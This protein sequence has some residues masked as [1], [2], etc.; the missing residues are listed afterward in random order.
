MISLIAALDRRHAIGRPDLT[1]AGNGLPWHLPDDLRRF[2][3]LT[4]GKPVLMG[5]RT[6]LAIGRA[7]PGRP[8]LVLSRRRDAPFEGQQTLRSFDEAVALHPDLVVGGGGEIYALTIPYAD[9]LYLT[10]VDADL[11]DADT[12]FPPVRPAL[13]R[14][15]FREHHPADDRHAHPFDWVDYAPAGGVPHAF[16]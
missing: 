10:W 7:L 4:L 2:K 12:Y 16:M 1:G 6:A 5:Y 15:V 11:G 14:E 3:T 9:R 13:W 8:N